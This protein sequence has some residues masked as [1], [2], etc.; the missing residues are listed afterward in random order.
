MKKYSLIFFILISVVHTN[1]AQEPFE[2]GRMNRSTTKTWI[3]KDQPRD[4]N[5][6][7]S[8]VKNRL[9]TAKR[10]FDRAAE[11][12][13]QAESE[14]YIY[15]TFRITDPEGRPFID[16]AIFVYNETMQHSYGATTDQNGEAIIGSPKGDYVYEVTYPGYLSQLGSIT[17]EKDQVFNLT[18]STYK[19][20]LIEYSGA[21]ASRNKHIF[22]TAKDNDECNLFAQAEIDENILEVYLPYGEYEWDSS[23]DQYVGKTGTF[24]FSPTNQTLYLDYTTYHKIS[25]T[26]EFPENCTDELISVIIYD[27]EKGK[28]IH[29]Y[30]E[31]G[32]YYYFLPDGKYTWRYSFS[33]EEYD[34]GIFSEIQAEFFVE[35]ASKR[36]TAVHDPSVY[37]PAIFSIYGI[38]D[39]DKTTYIDINIQKDNETYESNYIYL[40]PGE[41]FFNKIIILPKGSYTAVLDFEIDNTVL[42]SSIRQDFTING[43]TSITRNLATLLKKYT[44]RIKDRNTGQTVYPATGLAFDSSKHL[45]GSFG[46]EAE[47]SEFTFYAVSGRYSLKTIA[48]G[49]YSDTR[50]LNVVNTIAENFEIALNPGNVC[51]VTFITSNEKGKEIYGGEITL[52]GYGTTDVNEELGYGLFFDV[53]MSDTPI[54][55]TLTM[56]GYT[57]VAGTI[58]ANEINYHDEYWGVFEEVVLR[59]TTKIPENKTANFRVYPIPSTDYIYVENVEEVSGEWVAALY[60]PN[61]LLVKSESLNANNPRLN[62]S[63]LKN[64]IYLLKLTNGNAATTLK[65]IKK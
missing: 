57:P 9:K 52:Q 56:P 1:R 6:Q 38:P 37:L 39:L 22:I 50:E 35:R 44:F 62:I 45:C 21:E 26:I 34:D 25:F 29:D 30:A 47:D 23:I 41:T 18:F 49:Y 11:I 65:V 63:E 46:S 17:V 64:G 32:D 14:E 27:A 13:E 58:T 60:L 59:S 31:N 15:T 43:E 10:Y 12:A 54:P 19:K 40:Y 20:L 28:H 8:E 33:R 61:G 16:V 24:I 2:P 36:L 48:K 3:A 55:Y 42:I 4:N 7:K 51:P 5:I 53:E